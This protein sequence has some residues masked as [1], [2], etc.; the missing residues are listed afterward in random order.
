M[1]F[2]NGVENYE[3][4]IIQMQKF[5]ILNQFVRSINKPR[6]SKIEI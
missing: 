2:P 6:G 5:L 1:T 3:L 4:G